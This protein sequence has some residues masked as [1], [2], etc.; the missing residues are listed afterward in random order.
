P[1]MKVLISGADGVL[2][3]DLR[4]ILDPTGDILALGKTGMDV[5]NVER[6]FDIVSKFH[7]DV[8][9]HCAA[10]TDIDGCEQNPAQA[11]HVNAMGAQNVALACL[12]HNAAMMYISCDNIFDGS[13]ATPYWEYDYPN[14]PSI[15]GKSKQAGE[16]SVLQH[17]HK[18]WIIRTGWL[19]GRTK[20]SYVRDVLTLSNEKKTIRAAHDEVGTPTYTADLAVGIR[21]L[22]KSP[23]YGI[24]HITNSGACSREQFAKDI[25][26]AAGRTD[27]VAAISRADLKGRAPRPAYSVL[28]NSIFYL[29]GFKPLRDY[30][31]ALAAFVKDNHL[32]EPPAPARPKSLPIK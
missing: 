19:F 12:Q 3:S 16:Q 31:E 6:V 22:I 25:L 11:F 15:Y 32:M 20:P 7:P 5:T 4:H 9:I 24:Y 18:W 29:R 1:R 28:N 17:L 23:F 8:V 30:R 21:E 26:L 27:P 2:G 13:S 10:Y 14:P